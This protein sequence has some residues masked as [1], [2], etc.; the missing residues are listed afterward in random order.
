MPSSEI[1]LRG[2]LLAKPGSSLLATLSPIEYDNELDMCFGY[3]TCTL[4][5]VIK[6][7]IYGARPS[8]VVELFHRFIAT[9]VS[10]DLFL[11]DGT[12]VRKWDL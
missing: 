2:R 11:S 5:D 9:M 1:T 10:R 7:P 8:H 3:A 6:Q 12:E 4:F